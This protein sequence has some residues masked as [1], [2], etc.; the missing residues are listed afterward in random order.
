MRILLKLTCFILLLITSC[1]EKE[2]DKTTTAYVK[3]ADPLHQGRGYYKLKINYEYSYKG[4]Q[5][6]NS[7]DHGLGK[8]YNKRAFEI[9]DS[10]LIKFLESDPNESKFVKI[11]YDKSFRKQLK[12]IVFDKE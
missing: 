8:I 3:K 12:K 11:T 7:F 6:Q 4:N 10:I 1:T 5:Y 2:Y 9:G